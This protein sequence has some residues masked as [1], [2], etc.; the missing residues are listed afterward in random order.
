MRLCDDFMGAKLEEY[1]EL[2]IGEYDNAKCC[3]ESAPRKCVS[4]S[5]GEDRIIHIYACR[6]Q[7]FGY[8]KDLTGN[9]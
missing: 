1:T 3:D 4:A 9:E 6:T 8:E 7:C 5:I 2:Y